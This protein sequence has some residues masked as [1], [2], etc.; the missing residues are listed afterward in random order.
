MV[1]ESGVNEAKFFDGD[2]SNRLERVQRRSQLAEEAV[3]H[4]LSGVPLGHKD[5]GPE[6]T[7]N[8]IRF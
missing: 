2:F 7:G 6:V 8:G 1:S 3:P 4:T 5:R